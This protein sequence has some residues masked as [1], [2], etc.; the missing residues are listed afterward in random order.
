MFRF[1][2]ESDSDNEEQLAS[3]EEAQSYSSESDEG[4][5]KSMADYYNDLETIIANIREEIKD[6]DKDPAFRHAAKILTKV[7]KLCRDIESS[8]NPVAVLQTNSERSRLLKTLG[9]DGLIEVKGEASRSLVIHYQKLMVALANKEYWPNP[10]MLFAP[11]VHARYASELEKRADETQLRIR[12]YQERID[13][14]DKSQTKE[15]PEE[16]QRR[17][18]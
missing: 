18:P 11:L 7:I 6:A 16:L 10:P 13:A 8:I 1:F 2:G 12:K 5:P 9:P 3:N 14:Y 17:R 4:E 15:Q